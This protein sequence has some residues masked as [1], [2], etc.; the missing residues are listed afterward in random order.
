MNKILVGAALLAVSAASLPAQSTYPMTGKV[1]QITPYAGYMVFGDYFETSNG[2]EFSNDNSSIVGAQATIQVVPA[3]ALY[4]NFGYAKSNW[5]F[6]NFFGAGGDLEL[7]DVGIWL[8]DGGLQLRVPTGGTFSPFAQVG[9]GA[10]R[11]TLDTDDIASDGQTNFAFNAGV[12]FD[13]QLTRAL[14]LRLMAKDYITSL[15]WDDP[16]EVSIRDNTA[17]NFGFS[18]GLNLG[19]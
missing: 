15:E 13:Y 17:H 8:F 4:G 6:E 14:G 18:L 12:G 19:F 1:F 16:D 11:Y 2:V 3:V 9:A 7:D 5:T 10:F